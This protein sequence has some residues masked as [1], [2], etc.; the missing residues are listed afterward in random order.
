MKRL[1]LFLFLMQMMLTVTAERR[2]SIFADHIAD[3]A[4][5]QQVTYREAAQRIYDMGYRGA[6][7]RYNIDPEELAALEEIGFEHA[8]GI[9]EIN[10]STGDHAEEVSRS[11]DF[12]LS[13]GYKRVL[14]VPGLLPESAP[15][16]LI[17]L[18]Y[19]RIRAYSEACLAAGLDVM[20]EDYDNPR[21]LCYN[22]EAL[23]RLFAQVPSLTHVF[24]SGNYCYAGDDVIEA[25]GRYLDRIHHVHLK[26]RK[27]MRD[28][29]SPAVGSG[30]LPMRTIMARLLANGYD[31]W[32]TVEHFG[33][34]DQAGYAQRSIEAVNALY[35][36]LGQ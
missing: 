25:L 32:F 17:P 5:Q 10:F 22:M 30:I 8:C 23:D 3:M 36:E 35:D 9:A 34:P 7:V 28:S 14:L 24:D 19:Q 29:A 20:V 4:R 27:A 2:I 13:H 15:A 1:I 31:G 21:S 12:M 11:I 18:I 16:E 33:A 6:D 26:D